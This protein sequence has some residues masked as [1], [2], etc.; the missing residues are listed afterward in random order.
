MSGRVGAGSGRARAVEGALRRCAGR[1]PAGRFV[2][3]GDTKTALPLGGSSRPISTRQ[4]DT[5][6]RRVGQPSPATHALPR[7]RGGPS[8]RRRARGGRHA[9]EDTPSPR[10]RSVLRAAPWQQPRQSG[11][12][13]RSP[14]GVGSGSRRVRWAQG[15]GRG[16]KS[17]RPARVALE[18]GPAHDAGR[19]DG[20]D[21]VTTLTGASSYRTSPPAGHRATR[22]ADCCQRPSSDSCRGRLAIG[23]TCCRGR[24]KAWGSR[25][26]PAIAARRSSGVLPALDPAVGA[27][28][29]TR[30]HR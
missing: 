16:S 3:T 5:R 13:A 20:L 6:F 17:R 14:R 19:C 21:A 15:G 26:R 24:Q 2:P 23:G 29:P 18:S 12:N 25:S 30:R 10:S 8:T 7:V 27:V 11:G 9:A 4:P 28:D 1:C 22:T